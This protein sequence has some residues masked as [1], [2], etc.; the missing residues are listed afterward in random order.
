MK[1]SSAAKIHPE[2]CLVYVTKLMSD[3]N[4]RQWGRDFSNGQAKK[5]DEERSG[6]PGIQ[7]EEIGTLTVIVVL[8]SILT[9]RTP[10][11]SQ[12]P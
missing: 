8:K 6:T 10:F 9:K 11:S 12:R 5:H 3:E 2:L 4:V 1:V 7:A